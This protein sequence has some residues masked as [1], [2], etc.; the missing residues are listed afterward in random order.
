MSMKGAKTDQP[1]QTA[2]SVQTEVQTVTEALPQGTTTTPATRY[3]TMAKLLT[4]CSDTGDLFKLASSDDF[5]AA[6]TTLQPA[7][8]KQLRE[9]YRSRKDDLDGK[10]RLNEFDGQIINITDVQ[11][12]HTDKFLDKN[13]S[14][15]GV[16]LSYYPEN[17][18]ERKCRSMTS[19]SIVY[20]FA[21][22]ICSPMPPTRS[23]PARAHIELVPVK[24]AKRAAEGQ[25]QWQFRLLPTLARDNGLEGSPF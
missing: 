24:D 22:S 18:P 21:T 14:G 16:T 1:A 7:E 12:W 19:S 5:R 2:P 6:S 4:D 3:S 17:E 10:T 13:P 25:K 15:N 8:L 20:R 23:E 11:F 9:L